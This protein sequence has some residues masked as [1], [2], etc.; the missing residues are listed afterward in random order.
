MASEMASG[1]NAGVAGDGGLFHAF[2]MTPEAS[3]KTV[4]LNV[5]E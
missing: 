4:G 3:R 5:P 2:N 1:K